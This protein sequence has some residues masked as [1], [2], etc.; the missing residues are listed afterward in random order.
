MAKQNVPWQAI[1]LLTVSIAFLTYKNVHTRSSKLY[2]LTFA[3]RPHPVL[4]QLED[5]VHSFGEE[6]HVLGRQENRDI[7][8]RSGKRNFGIKLRE[9]YAFVHKVELQP[10]DILLVSDAYDVAMIRPQKEIR[11]R[12]QTLFTKPIVFGAETNCHPDPNLAPQYGYHSP[13]EIFPY[14]NSGLFIGRVWAIRKCLDGYTYKDEESDQHY[15]TKQYLRR[16]DLIELDT[17][18]KLFLNCHGLDPKDIEYDSYKQSVYFKP[19]GTYPLFIHANGTDR[20]YLYPI[21]GRWTEPPKKI[22]TEVLNAAQ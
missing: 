19:Y 7:G 16:R 8:W 20:S 2:Q 14:L 10:D 11:R 12:Y 4:T 21:I 22:E 17:G 9:L 3:T 13:S 18:A 1:V 5:R 15:W 6:L